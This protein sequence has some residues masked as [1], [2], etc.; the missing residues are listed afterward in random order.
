MIAIGKIMESSKPTESLVLIGDAYAFHATDVAWLD[1]L[2]NF[3]K[4]AFLHTGAQRYPH[5]YAYAVGQRSE[6]DCFREFKDS[7]GEI[8]TLFARFSHFSKWLDTEVLDAALDILKPKRFILGY[9]CHLAK[10]M[11]KE[12]NAFERANALVLLNDRQK[13]YFQQIYSVE[14]IPVCTLRSMYLP[15]ISWYGDYPGKRSGLSFGL[16]G[17]SIRPHGRYSVRPF[18]DVL[19]PYFDRSEAVATIFG[20]TREVAD[21]DYMSA[22]RNCT[23]VQIPGL[24]DPKAYQAFLESSISFGSLNGFVR[25]DEPDQFD[26]ENYPIRLNSYLKANVVPVSYRSGYLETNRIMTEEG[27]GFVFD[28]YEEISELF[29]SKNA[30]ASLALDEKQWLRVCELNSLGYHS[31]K[32]INFIRSI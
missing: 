21:L 20:D 9:H 13:N 7:F 18:V 11:Q 26:K 2:R 24:L 10:E 31:D 32:L 29:T 4:R 3:E 28:D 5:D 12:R 14:S 15:R 1:F 23:S 25:A 8:G 17:Q 16:G 22:L 30:V 27:F 19:M 6:V